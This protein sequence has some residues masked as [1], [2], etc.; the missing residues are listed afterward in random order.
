MEARPRSRGAQ[1]RG[2]AAEVG[3]LVDAHGAGRR[4]ATFHAR[5]PH[6]QA[7]E[8][9]FMRA[10]SHD[11]IAIDD[12]PLFGPG[13]A[14]A[15]AA[16]RALSGGDLKGPMKPIDIGVTATLDGLDVDPRRAKRDRTRGTAEARTDGGRVRSRKDL[17]SR[18]DRD[19]APAAARCVRR[20]AGQVSAGRL[21]GR[22]REAGEALLAELA[23]RALA[24][25]KRVADR[26]G[27]ACAFA[28]RRA[29]RREA[30]AADADVAAIAAL[31]RAAATTP[32]LAQARRRDA[33]SF[34]PSAESP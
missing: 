14:G 34:P 28:L 21:P 18:R 33:R 13:M 7:D 32:G 6:G 17:E 25:T 11:I 27:G 1:A 16:A 24:L 31:T 15:I 26:F 2:V 8:V 10:R 9:G 20:G 3:E 22:P 19:R 23:E 12:C 29:R 4:R 30:F 5:F